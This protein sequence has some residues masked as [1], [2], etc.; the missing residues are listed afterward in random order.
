MGMCAYFFL[1]AFAVFF[2]FSLLFEP[3]PLSPIG[4]SPMFLMR[5]DAAPAQIGIVRRWVKS[6][7]PAARLGTPALIHM[8]EIRS[9]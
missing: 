6:G 3:G 7:H 2:F 1:S 8:G 9:I 4:L 5:A